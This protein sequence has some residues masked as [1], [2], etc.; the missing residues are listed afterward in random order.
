M[1]HASSAKHRFRQA[2]AGAPDQYGRQLAEGL[3]YLAKAIEEIQEGQ[4]R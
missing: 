2:K 3:E 4:Q 1:S